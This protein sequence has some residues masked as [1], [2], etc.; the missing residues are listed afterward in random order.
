MG[1]SLFFRHRALIGFRAPGFGKLGLVIGLK[2]IFPKPQT[3]NPKLLAFSPKP[4]RPLNVLG[5]WTEAS[6]IHSFWSF[7]VAADSKTPLTQSVWFPQPLNPKSLNPKSLNP[8]PL[9]LKPDCGGT[10]AGG[11][12]VSSST[13][14]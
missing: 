6:L 12:H 8:K 11:F 14:P 9:N 4:S 1:S 2:E 3:L 7:W 13:K 10:F 5:L